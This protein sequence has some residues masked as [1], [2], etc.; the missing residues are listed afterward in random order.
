MNKRKKL[1]ED[2]LVC[3]EYG[4]AFKPYYTT[5]E[6]LLKNQE[7]AAYRGF[8]KLRE[9]REQRQRNTVSASY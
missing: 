7:N 9:R 2:L 6:E 1:T 8:L 3:A 4:A 5:P